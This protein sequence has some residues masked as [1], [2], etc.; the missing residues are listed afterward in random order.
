MPDPFT[1][2]PDLMLGAVQGPYGAAI[3]IGVEAHLLS[4]SL[5]PTTYPWAPSIDPGL[6][7]SFGQS[8]T[9]ALSMLSGAVGNVLHLIPAPVIR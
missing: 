3:E 8:S 2:I 9:T 7:V 1:V 4:P 6:N 5:F